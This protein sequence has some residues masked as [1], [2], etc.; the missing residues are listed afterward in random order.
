MKISKGF[1]L[2]MGLMVLLFSYGCAK[3]ITLSE[4]YDYNSFSSG[5]SIYT[6]LIDHTLKV[7]VINR[8]SVF[9]QIWM[10]HKYSSRIKQGD[11]R[12]LVYE[13]RETKYDIVIEIPIDEIKTNHSFSIKINDIDGSILYTTPILNLKHRRTR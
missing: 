13:G 2:T 5:M 8:Q 4:G 1:F 12:Q 9:Y 3:P 6:E 11:E 7:G 10:K